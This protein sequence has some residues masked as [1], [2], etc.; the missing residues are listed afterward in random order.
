M[1]DWLRFKRYLL[2]HGDR[3]RKFTIRTN[4]N[5]LSTRMAS[6]M[7]GGAGEFAGGGMDSSGQP[8]NQGFV[9]TAAP[10]PEMGACTACRGKRQRKKIFTGHCNRCRGGGC[11]SCNYCGQTHRSTPN[12]APLASPLRIAFNA[13][14]HTIA[15]RHAAQA[16]RSWLN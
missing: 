16:K 7:P 10:A 11:D 1:C 6:P 12:L 2:P 3:L 9:S 13:N 14:H 4:N 8:I 5:L 15:A